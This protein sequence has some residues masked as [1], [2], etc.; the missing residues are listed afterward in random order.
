ML[1][2]LHSSLLWEGGDVAGELAYNSRLS[3]TR[4]P[5]SL[6]PT[7]TKNA[8]GMRVLFNPTWF[9]VLPGA[10][11]IVPIGLG[12]N[13]WGNSSVVQLFN[14]GA[15][16]GGD[17]T[18]GANVAFKTVWKAGLTYTKYFAFGATHNPAN[19]YVDR[20][21]VALSLQRTF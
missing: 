2:A 11:V 20:G 3:V 14:G 18:T 16:R 4:N 7:T 21:F 8:M 19:F 9:Q 12:Y 13:F 6:D 5:T 17:I 1:Y 15:V 10:D